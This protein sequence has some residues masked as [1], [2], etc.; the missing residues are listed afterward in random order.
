MK[1]P[2]SHQIAELAESAIIDALEPWVVEPIRRDYGKDLRVEVFCKSSDSEE[3]E[4][5]GVEFYIQIKS[6]NTT[7]P[8]DVSIFPIRVEHLEYWDSHALPVLLVRF[9][10]P[11]RTL[12]SR[13]TVTI[14]IKHGQA[15]QRIKIEH[16]PWDDTIKDQLYEEL[17][18]LSDLKQGSLDFPLIITASDRALFKQLKRFWQFEQLLD[19]TN[20]SP[21]WPSLTTFEDKVIVDFGITSI[22]LKSDSPSI[23]RDVTTAIAVILIRHNYSGPGARLLESSLNWS[24]FSSNM[25]FAFNGNAD[26]SGNLLIICTQLA[27]CGRNDII[28]Q[29]LYGILASTVRD[30]NE[31]AEIVAECLLIACCDNDIDILDGLTNRQPNLVLPAW[32]CVTLAECYLK[33]KDAD[34][35]A[36]ALDNALEKDARLAHTPRFLRAAGLVA[37]VQNQIEKAITEL[38]RATQLGDPLA[39]RYVPL[40]LIDHGRYQDAL[41]HL[42]QL[43]DLTDIEAGDRLLLKLVLEHVIEVT[44]ITDQIRYPK[45]AMRT[46]SRL[47]D[48]SLSPS[49]CET[50]LQ[51]AYQADAAWGSVWFNR[52]AVQQR[53]GKN[54]FMDYLSAAVLCPNDL[55]AW[56]HTMIF[57]IQMTEFIDSTESAVEWS[58]LVISAA[59]R[60]NGKDI[61]EELVALP[62]IFYEEDMR[63]LPYDETVLVGDHKETIKKLYSYFND[64]PS[65]SGLLEVW[66]PNMGARAS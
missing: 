20:L 5:T 1:R 49:Q 3:A 10:A 47:C 7:R 24:A 64:I 42:N 63:D 44:N 36:H 62:S 27:L 15:T 6:T 61:L 23:C 25:A 43:T 22:E 53:Q 59:K 4:S 13:W 8:R 12:Y 38:K 56:I 51:E 21:S 26:M 50:I 37:G 18:F 31:M 54:S 19:V 46:S 52:G 55:T 28:A 58:K 57:S 41:E 17:L 9:H 39:S 33:L 66:R 16:T 45:Q 29:I 35:A 2:K 65:G 48:S 30:A 40:M 34:R 14:P 11:T 32:L 60:T